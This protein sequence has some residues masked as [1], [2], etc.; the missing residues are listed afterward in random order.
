M[1]EKRDFKVKNLTDE[2]IDFAILV[3]EKHTN[4]V[5]INQKNGM[6]IKKMWL[7]DG[8]ICVKLENGDWYHYYKNLTWG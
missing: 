3:N 5:G 7:E 8:L 4:S 1:N 6:K 2:Q